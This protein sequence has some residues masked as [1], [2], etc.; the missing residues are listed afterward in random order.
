MRFVS[1]CS[2]ALI[3]AVSLLFS[4]I[5][6]DPYDPCEDKSCGQTCRVCDPDDSACVETPVTKFCNNKGVCAASQTPPAC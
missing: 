6:C 5:G 2:L 4:S 3:W 1:R